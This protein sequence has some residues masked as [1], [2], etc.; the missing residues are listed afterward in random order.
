MSLGCT[1]TFYK[2]GINPIQSCRISDSAFLLLQPHT[3]YRIVD[4]LQ[5]ALRC[6]DDHDDTL[7]SLFLLKIPDVRLIRVLVGVLE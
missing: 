2:R 4:P 1:L 6:Q 5:A 7:L 3:S